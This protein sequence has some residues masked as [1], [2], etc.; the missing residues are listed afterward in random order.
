VTK[1]EIETIGKKPMRPSLYGQYLTREE[2]DALVADL[3]TER[4]RREQA[5]AERDEAKREWF[6][7]LKKLKDGDTVHANMLRGCIA[8]PTIRQML[9]LHGEDALAKWDRAEQAEQSLAALREPRD[10]LNKELWKLA[11]EGR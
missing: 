7:L 1:E 6:N 5:E 2:R 4:Q 11:E 9:H 10:R 3:L 8:T